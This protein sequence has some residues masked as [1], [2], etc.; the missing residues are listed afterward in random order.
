METCAH[1]TSSGE[2]LAES[3][4]DLNRIPPELK[5]TITSNLEHEDLCSIRLAGREFQEA[6]TIRLFSHFRLYPF[7]FSINALAAI[8][9]SH[10]AGHVIRLTVCTAGLKSQTEADF[11]KARTK[12]ERHVRQVYCCSTPEHHQ[13]E[14]RLNKQYSQTMTALRTFEGIREY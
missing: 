12:I 4:F 2:D 3:Y 5:L 6:A 13:T 7:R 9:N 14:R 11:H 8:A 1:I 10:L